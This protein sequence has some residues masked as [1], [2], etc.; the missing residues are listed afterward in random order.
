MRQRPPAAETAGH[1]ASGPTVDLISRRRDAT[2]SPMRVENLEA[3]L[4]QLRSVAAKLI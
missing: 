2:T 3:A 4:E 1:A